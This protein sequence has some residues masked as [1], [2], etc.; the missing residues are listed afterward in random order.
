MRRAR[1]R[2]IILVM[3]LLLGIISIK[4][5]FA[6]T[7]ATFSASCYMPFYVDM[8]EGKMAPTNSENNIQEA[9]TLVQI[10]EIK[11]ESNLTQQQEEIISEDSEEI[12]IIKTV[13]AK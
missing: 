8:P 13:C 3:A 7:S 12:E 6:E 1:E 9:N 11:E 2:A 4:P 5:I 10:N